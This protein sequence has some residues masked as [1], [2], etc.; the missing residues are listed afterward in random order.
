MFIRSRKAPISTKK[1][2]TAPLEKDC[3]GFFVGEGAGALVLQRQSIAEKSGS[4][5]YASICGI[6]SAATIEECSVAA[7]GDAN[8]TANDVE[9]LEVSADSAS[10]AGA[11]LESLAKTYSSKN[12]SGNSVKKTLAVGTVKAN[13]GHAGY[14]SGAAA[15]IK[16]ALSLRN[17]YLPEFPRWSGPSRSAA[18]IFSSSAMY[19]CPDSRAWVKNKGQQRYAAVS[20][21]GGAGS[22]FHVLV[23]DVE[24]HAEKM[25][26][27]S[28][29]PTEP[30]LVVISG[31][32]ANAIVSKLHKLVADIDAEDDTGDRVFRRCLRDTVEAE[33]TSNSGSR[34][35]A[36]L[37]IVSTAKN[38]KKEISMAIK[39][40][41][42]AVGQ[43]KDWKSPSGSYFAVDPIN[44]D[45][46]AFMYGDG[47]SPY[48]GLGR[49]LN[50]VVPELH[51]IVHHKTTDMWSVSDEAWNCRVVD[52]GEVSA[53]AKQFEKR[54]VDMFR[55]GVYH[56]VCFTAIA[57]DV[58]GISPRASFGLSMGEVAMLFAF[59]NQNSRQSDTMIDRLNTSAVWTSALAVDF[60]S[61]RKQWNISSDAPVESFWQGYL[62]RASRTAVERALASRA[63]S[64]S[65]SSS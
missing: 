7:L 32:S 60:K 55:S 23:S 49:D 63:R 29:S 16:V 50:R 43:K 45:K 27:F 37:C 34:N 54:Q 51:E 19:V 26:M 3:D 13:I 12:V 15:L 21:V 25:N 65:G 44:S 53:A 11:E 10:S 36:K 18:D 17:R 6:R 4:K 48:A 30:K 61:L 35:Q 9:Y 40:L 2:P 5:M 33:S 52:S 24:G 20:G 41:P 46:I 22:C 31:D 57:K 62:V 39:G 64:T 8:I 38:F 58:L 28:L 14:A 47:A 1:E 59:S 56:S 42:N